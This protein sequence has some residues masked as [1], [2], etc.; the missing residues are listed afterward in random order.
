ML[1]L[2]YVFIKNTTLSNGA[3]QQVVVRKKQQK[4]QSSMPLLHPLNLPYIIVRLGIMTNDS[5]TT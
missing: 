3:F 2:I 5:C 1:V 4:Y